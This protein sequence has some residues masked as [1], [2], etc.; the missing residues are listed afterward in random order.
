MT[1]YQAS[2]IKKRRATNTEMEARAAFHQLAEGICE[3]SSTMASRTGIVPEHLGEQELDWLLTLG[4]PVPTIVRPSMIK[5]AT[6]TKAHD[7]LFE[8]TPA[9]ERWLVVETEE[10]LVFWNPRTNL[11]ATD[12]AHAFAL[13]EEMISAAATYSFD[14]A[15]NIFAHPLDWLHRKRDGIVV[16]PDQWHR[17]FDQLRDAPRIHL[18]ESLLPLYRR[19]MRPARVPELFVMTSQGVAP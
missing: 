16:L 5:V 8:P 9:G 12:V 3:E 18:A 10:D 14:C 19:Y 17:A 7:G 4:V 11:F 6:G 2:P 15:L 1:V 13:G